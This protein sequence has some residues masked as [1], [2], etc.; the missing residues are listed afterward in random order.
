MGRFLSSSLPPLGQRRIQSEGE[1][2]NKTGTGKEIQLIGTI[3]LR[4]A[5]PSVPCLSVPLPLP[6]CICSGIQDLP[7]FPRQRKLKVLPS[8]RRGRSICQ[9]VQ[10]EVVRVQGEDHGPSEALLLD[11]A[12]LALDAAVVL[13]R[14]PLK[15]RVHVGGARGLVVHGVHVEVV[16]LEPAHLRV[17][18]EAQR[19]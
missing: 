9:A 6:K 16:E 13:I 14:D 12:A 8:G 4:N 15:H 5:A 7:H 19:P 2:G 18:D 3:A 17:R 11:P 10:V 1:I